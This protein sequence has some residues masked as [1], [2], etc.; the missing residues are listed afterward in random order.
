[1]KKA[2]LVVLAVLVA[3]MVSNVAVAILDLNSAKARLIKHVKA[4]NEEAGWEIFYGWQRIATEQD[5]IR[6]SSYLQQMKED[7]SGLGLLI[8]RTR[9]LVKSRAGAEKEPF[10]ALEKANKAK[11]D[12]LIVDAVKNA[13]SVNEINRMALEFETQRLVLKKTLEEVNRYQTK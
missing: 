6:I 11:A 5:Q 9:S 3:F 10:V 13:S 1:M 8:H 7:G 2:T 12:L 4:V